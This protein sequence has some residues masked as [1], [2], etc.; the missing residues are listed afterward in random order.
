MT[1]QVM[2]A[3]N[4]TATLVLDGEAL[5]EGR[6]AATDEEAVDKLK[7]H[8]AQML[9]RAPDLPDN[10]KEALQACVNFNPPT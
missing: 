5:C 7:K 9:A 8:C 10:W 6:P 3:R 2:V 4:C 1:I